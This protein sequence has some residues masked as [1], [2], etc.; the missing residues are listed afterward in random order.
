MLSQTDH[1]SQ[2]YNSH[3]KLQSDFKSFCKDDNYIPVTKRNFSDRIRNLGILIERKNYGMAVNVERII[4]STSD[5]NA[6]S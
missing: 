2:F 4:F 3:S 6:V 5:N 1:G